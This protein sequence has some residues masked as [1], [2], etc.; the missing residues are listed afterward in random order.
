MKYRQSTDIADV[1][2]VSIRH[3][4]EKSSSNRQLVHLTQR[5]GRCPPR[6]L[7]G[8]PEGRTLVPQHV[9]LTT[10]WHDEWEAPHLQALLHAVDTPCYGPLPLL[11]LVQSSFVYCCSLR[12]S[13]SL[14][15]SMFSSLNSLDFSVT[16][17]ILHLMFFLYIS[18]ILILLSF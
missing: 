10:L 14:F 1:R 4:D 12:P 5:R 7:Q 15:P 9:G 18:F 8:P 17:N 11:Q 6:S 3:H 16:P 2:H 13:L